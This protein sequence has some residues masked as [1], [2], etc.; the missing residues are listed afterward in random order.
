MKHGLQR[1]SNFTWQEKKKTAF[2]IINNNKKTKNQKHVQSHHKKLA[3]TRNIEMLGAVRF[4]ILKIFF[5][6]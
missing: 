4:C 5:K 6:N 1:K 3:G 2:E